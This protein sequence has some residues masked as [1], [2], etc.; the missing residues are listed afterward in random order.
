MLDMK[1]TALSY[2][3][4]KMHLYNIKRAARERRNLEIRLIVSQNMYQGYTRISSNKYE[5]HTHARSQIAII[6]SVLSD[7]TIVV[8]I[9]I[10]EKFIDCERPECDSIAWS[11]R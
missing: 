10:F 9:L 3:Y 1:R 4:K 8:T 7:F 2:N 5:L 6:L 11:G